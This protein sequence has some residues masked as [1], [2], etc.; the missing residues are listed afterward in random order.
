MTCAR[1]RRG[2]IKRKRKT[3]TAHAVGV[4]ACSGCLCLVL[5]VIAGFL[6]PVVQQQKHVGP[7]PLRDF[8]CA[9]DVVSDPLFAG[10]RL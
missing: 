7:L 8:G 10:G 1:I 9:C 3:P 2:T 5:A 4:F 6:V